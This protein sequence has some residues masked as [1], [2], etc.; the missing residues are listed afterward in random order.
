VRKVSTAPAAPDLERANLSPPV[1]VRAPGL[2]HDSG[3]PWHT[4]RQYPKISAYATLLGEPART[5]ADPG[6]DT[7]RRRVRRDRSPAG[8]GAG[9]GR[10]A[11]DAM[12]VSVISDSTVAALCALARVPASALRFRPNIVVTPESGTPFQEDDW[13]GSAVRI[14]AAVV[15]IDRR[16][17]RCTIVNVDP[18]TGRPD[19]RLLKA[20][21]TARGTRAGVYATTVQPGL[22][23]VGDPVIAERGAATDSA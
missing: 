10:G 18:A 22:I 17:S 5:G 21:G 16:D 2:L 3:L 19:S 11:F 7:G 13:A 20:I 12:P 9:H 15:R 6:K 8:R 14:G 23:R 1:G 4:I